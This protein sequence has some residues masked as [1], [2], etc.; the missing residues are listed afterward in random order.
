[1]LGV[2]FS[3][4]TASAQ[5]G[6]EMNTPVMQ[7]VQRNAMKQNMRT[8]WDGNGTNLMAINLIQQ[9]E[10]R[11]GIGVTNEQ[12]QRLHLAMKSMG[13]N[14]PNDPEVKPI[15]EEVDRL[16]RSMPGGPFGENVSDETRERFFG[17][18]LQIQDIAVRRMG[19]VVQ[20]NLTPEQL[21]KVNEFQIATMSENPI[22]S[23][24]M[25]EAL[26]LSP[27]QRKQLETIKKE[28]EPEFE[29]NMDKLVDAQFRIKER[30]QGELDDKLAGVTD[31]EQRKKIS[32][33]ILKKA[34]AVDPEVQKLEKEILGSSR[35]FA[36]KLK[37][38]MFDV[39][40]DEQMD[41]MTDLI[42]NPPDY[43]KKLLDRARRERRERETV[44]G[45]W[46]P[47]LDSWKPGDPIPEE[48]LEQRKER[49][50][51]FPKK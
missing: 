13:D 2:A 22:I 34:L 46:T 12:Q 17:L 21:K 9:D 27:D 51:N 29:K 49:K 45:E 16:A 6:P 42:D 38:R 40:T 26:D 43:V 20:Q 33:E 18:Q 39:L 31:P 5:D 50:K 8:F 3:L 19:G 14:L 7:R 24:G 4:V 37:T 36:T 10:F 44:L 11:Q 1:M 35:E 23:P 30:I 28:M 15:R 48:Y 41:R 32:D 25:F 47:G